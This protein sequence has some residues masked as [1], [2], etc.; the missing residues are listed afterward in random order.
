MLNKK[1]RYPILLF[2]LGVIIILATSI[3]ALL[4]DPIFYQLGWDSQHHFNLVNDTNRLAY[5]PNGRFGYAF[6]MNKSAARSSLFNVSTG[7][8]GNSHNWWNVTLGY[9]NNHT[10]EFWFKDNSTQRPST[11]DRYI[12]GIG[13]S[14]KLAVKT[15]NGR[16]ILTELASAFNGTANAI[17]AYQAKRID[18]GDTFWTS[19]G[20]IAYWPFN[21][22]GNTTHFKE[23]AN[24]ASNFWAK[25]GF[26]STWLASNSY[27]YYPWDNATSLNI[28]KKRVI[29]NVTYPS[30]LNRSSGTVSMLVKVNGRAGSSSDTL[31]CQQRTA[32]GSPCG[33]QYGVGI[34]A[35][36]A[37][38]TDNA[39]D[40]VFYRATSGV[41]TCTAQTSKRY[42][43][44]Q[45][46]SIIANWNTFVSN[47][48]G[49]C[50][51]WVN[52]SLA[53][54]DT[55]A[56]IDP[57]LGGGGL[58]SFAPPL[59]IGGT[60]D[61]QPNVGL[62][63]SI[64]EIAIFRQQLNQSDIQKIAWSNFTDN[65]W[66][67]ARVNF[68]KAR[69]VAGISRNFLEM[70]IDGRYYGQNNRGLTLNNTGNLTTLGQDHNFVIGDYYGGN[71]KWYGLIDEFVIWNASKGNSWNG[72]FVPPPYRP[73]R[74]R[75]TFAMYH[76]GDPLNL[77]IP[78]SFRNFTVRYNGSLNQFWARKI[79][80]DALT[81]KAMIKFP[82]GTL[83]NRTLQYKF[84]NNAVNLSSHNNATGL[85]FRLPGQY[86]I[87]KI[88]VQTVNYNIINYTMVAGLN[89]T[90][91]GRPLIMRCT[92]S[93]PEE[94][95]LAVNYTFYDE[96]NRTRFNITSVEASYK[97][98]DRNNLSAIT[99]LNVSITN[100]PRY[101]AVCVSP[102]NHIFKL[103]GTIK[104]SKDGFNYR[105]WYYTD[106]KDNFTGNAKNTSIYLLKDAQAT[107]IS[108][109]V[110][111]SLD[112]ALKDIIT[113][114]HRLY[115]SNNTWITIGMIKSGE[116]GKDAIYLQQNE[117]DYRFDVYQNGK[118]VKLTTGQKLTAA[119]YTIKIIPATLSELISNVRNLITNL[120][121]NNHTKTFKFGYFDPNSKMAGACLQSSISN[122]TGRYYQAVNCTYGSFRG[123]IYSRPGNSTPSTSFGYGYIIMNGSILNFGK[124][125]LQAIEGL[126]VNARTWGKYGLYLLIILLT[127]LVTIAVSM[128]SPISAIVMLM[129]GLFAAWWMDIFSVTTLVF[130]GLMIGLAVIIKELRSG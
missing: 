9:G 51:L 88:F 100:K 73:K 102:K 55:S 86:N 1:F 78:S 4:N 112:T 67:H 111:D 48:S 29:M 19:R 66:H 10:F 71:E 49:T 31:V 119:T 54:Q 12:F 32:S 80:F 57:A 93:L 98:Q 34:I 62:N 126:H 89:W 94:F 43:K 82:N 36:P 91:S 123:F 110:T 79:G 46:Y 77:T 28:L 41:A 2:C 52:G 114:V 18:V 76:L 8:T 92:G 44:G 109:L 70:A 121:Y 75:N 45:W 65:Q 74:D 26:N 42:R 117:P 99:G 21:G 105:H 27:G 61:G 72:S 115:I 25:R 59:I 30:M 113:E 108:I 83:L 16:I 17:T 14:S 24:G 103:N 50:N 56:Y 15:D 11:E 104:A 22:T 101:F 5:N 127:M 58:D 40:F 68:Y 118:R 97:L 122:T 81:G 47:T 13:G 60:N 3:S 125:T 128:G 95:G 33:F 106:R 23:F 7:Q 120:T 129:V 35:L 96:V 130:T 37:V 64:D 124:Q 53:A 107:L 116:D 84:L 6:F 85:Q 69:N 39:V 38:V 87:T 63:G 20:L 90:V